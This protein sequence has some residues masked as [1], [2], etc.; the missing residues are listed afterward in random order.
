MKLTV[1]ERL[2]AGIRAVILPLQ[3]FIRARLLGMPGKGTNDL[4]S[5]QALKVRLLSG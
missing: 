5:L 1:P 3:Y 4:Q 2:V